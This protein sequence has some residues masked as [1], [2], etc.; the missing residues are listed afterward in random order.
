MKTTACT[1]QLIISCMWPTPAKARR[2]LTP[3]AAFTPITAKNSGSR[4]ASRWARRGRRTKP[5]DSSKLPAL[6]RKCGVAGNRWQTL[7]ESETVYGD[8]RA[9]TSFDIQ[10]FAGQKEVQFS[11]E[12]SCVLFFVHNES[13]N[14]DKAD[15]RS[16]DF[17]KHHVFA[18][19]WLVFRPIS[20]YI[21]LSSPQNR[22]H[23]IQTHIAST[24]LAHC[25]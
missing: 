20:A 15:V 13:R 19:V 11:L 9:R 10:G 12:I 3:Q 16:A 17:A 21:Q 5:R 24:T 2:V 8:V 4:K 14:K 7:L 22:H 6:A 25:G 1:R 18:S 23:A